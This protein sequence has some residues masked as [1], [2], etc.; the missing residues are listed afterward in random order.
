MIFSYFIIIELL[1]ISYVSMNVNITIDLRRT[2]SC[3]CLNGTCDNNTGYCQTCN[4][5]YF[6]SYLPTNECK[7]CLCVHGVCNDGI[8]GNGYC[9]TCDKGYFSPACNCTKVQTH[10]VRSVSELLIVIIYIIMLNALYVALLYRWKMNSLNNHVEKTTPKFTTKECY[11]NDCSDSTCLNS[12]L[13]SQTTISMFNTPINIELDNAT[14]NKNSQTPKRIPISYMDNSQHVKYKHTTPNMSKMKTYSD[15]DLSKTMKN[16]S[17]SINKGMKSTS[18]NIHKNPLILSMLDTNR[19]TPKRIPISHMDN[20]QHVKYKHTTPN[21]S[22]M[23]TY[24]DSDLSKTMKNI[25]NSINKGMKS[26]S[27]NIHKNPL[28]LSMLDTN[29]ITPKRIPISHMDNSQHVKYKHTTPN[30]SK[31][32]TYSDSDLSKTMKNISNSTN[33][34]MKSTSINIHKNPLILSMLDTNRITPKRIPISH[35][36]NSQH[37]KYKHT[38]PNM[39]KMKTYSDSD[40]SKT[41]KNISNSTNKGIKSRNI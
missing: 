11:N 36:D 7:P 19:I 22:K 8:H 3:I 5:G 10:N 16:I 1:L 17:N 41:M 27:I 25:S 6:T 4:R 33:K 26:T 2:K 15:S 39:S 30:M 14:D 18:I 28:I 31:M 32:K 35:M 23:K 29:R 13:D 20:S 21:M 38:T 24:S 37:V 12:L 40:L 9:K 34:G